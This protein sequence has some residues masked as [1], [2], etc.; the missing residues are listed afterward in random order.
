MKLKNLQ[1][2]ESNY[3]NVPKFTTNIEEVTWNF[4]AVRSSANVEERTVEVENK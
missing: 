2:L 1:I 4:S 3:F